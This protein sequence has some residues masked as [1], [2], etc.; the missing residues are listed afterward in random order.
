M[1]NQRITIWLQ[2]DIGELVVFICPALVFSDGDSVA[3]AIVP[4]HCLGC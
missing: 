2:K 4:S 1:N 3:A